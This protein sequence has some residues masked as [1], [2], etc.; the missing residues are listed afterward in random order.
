MKSCLLSPAEA[1]ISSTSYTIRD[2]LMKR[3][4]FLA[5]DLVNRSLGAEERDVLVENITDSQ[6]WV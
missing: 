2:C 5:A 4:L 3:E 6:L 1:A